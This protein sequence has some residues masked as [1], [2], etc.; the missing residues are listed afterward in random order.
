MSGADERS[1]RVRG[2]TAAL[3]GSTR[4]PS[5]KSIGHRAILIGALAEGTVEVSGF[6][7][8]E[9]NRRTLEIFRALGVRIDEHGGDRITVHGVGLDGLAPTMD[10]LECG[11]SGTTMRLMA[12]V[13]AAQRF[14]SRLVGDEY[15]ERRPM[16]RVV[17]PLVKMG[18]KLSGRAG[19]KAGEIYPPL[20]IAPLRDPLRGIEHTGTIASAQVKSAIL[21]AALWAEGPTVVREPAQSRDHTERMLKYL[22]APIEVSADGLTARIDPDTWDRRLEAR[23]IR[24]PGDLSAAAFVLGAGLLRAGSDVTVQAVGLNPTRTGLLDV[25]AQMG[26]PVELGRYEEDASEPIADVR[27][28][29]R[30]GSGLV[31]TTIAGALTVRAI[32]EIPLVA[33][34]AAHARGTTT[35]TDAGELR[36]KE[37]DRIAST[38]QMLSAFGVRVEERPDGLVIEGRGPG[39]AS[40]HPGTVESHGDHRIAMAGAVCASA[41]EGESLIRDT[42]NV[43]TSFPA[44]EASLRGLGVDVT[45]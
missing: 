41:I 8:G 14:T 17:D 26:A 37:S 35:I 33:A 36:V 16:K 28:R 4:V 27:V 9:D 11:N 40:L 20:D 5:D 18:G 31:G 1:W 6:S 32:D 10:D 38:A 44:F 24:V 29:V 15:L 22:G 43:A 25:L 21:L 12:G 45:D 39:A 7:G 23:A 30:A 2:A 3:G 42:A 19:I 13:L 34:L